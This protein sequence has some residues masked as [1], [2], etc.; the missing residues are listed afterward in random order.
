MHVT[1]IDLCIELFYAGRRRAMSAPLINQFQVVQAQAA[2]SLLD[3]GGRH[4]FG[5]GVVGSQPALWRRALPQDGE[6]L[7]HLL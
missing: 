6:P 3:R 1:E 2:A 5:L 4:K 7:A